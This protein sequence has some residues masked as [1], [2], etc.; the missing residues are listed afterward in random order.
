MVSSTYQINL[1]KARPHE[2]IDDFND[3]LNEDYWTA[4]E[5]GDNYNHELEYYHPNNITLQDSNLKITAKKED[6]NNYQYTSG[7]ITTKNKFSFLYGKIIFKAKIAL[8]KGLFSAIW[9]L[10][11]DDS[12]FP[13]VDII[14]VI[15]SEPKNIW[16]GVHYL[17]NGNHKSDFNN[18]NIN[19]TDYAT[20]EFDWNK[21]EMKL[22]I[23]NILV[24]T[25]IAG[26]PDKEM[27]LIINLAVGGDWPGNPED[28]ILP[29]DF[30]I[31]YLIIIPKEVGK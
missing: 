2:L 13:E 18:Y 5:K 20:Y 7:Y 23:N 22:Y 30:N 10:P 11:S 15:G 6:I 21:D 24:S 19:N 14:E 29:T 27:Y 25:K 1:V 4:V 9:L 17:D 3:G 26:I 12:L 28:K 31:D 16:T 8:G